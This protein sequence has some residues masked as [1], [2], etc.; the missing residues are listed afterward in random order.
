MNKHWKKWLITTIVLTTAVAP[1]AYTSAHASTGA[2]FGDLQQ[3]K[4]NKQEAIQQAAELGLIS[5]DPNGQFRP[6]D[7]VTREELAVLIS[8]ALKLQPGKDGSF[9]DVSSNLYGQT[10]IQAMQA[11][12]LMAGDEDHKFRPSDSITREELATVLVRVMDGLKIQGGTAGSVSD[13]GQ[14]SGWAQDYVDSALRLKLV[15]TDGAAFNPQGNVQR[16]DI[17][18]VLLDLFQPKQKTATINSVSGD[19]VT[20][21]GVPY[22]ATGSLKKLLSENNAAALTG[23]K[24]Q[25]D[26]MTRGINQLGE[27]SIV[28]SGD[29]D[30]PL[31]LDLGGA[32]LNG[33]LTISGDHVAITGTA[34]IS[35]LVLDGAAKSVK[36][37]ANVNKL[38]VKADHAVDLQGKGKVGELLVSNDKASLSLGKDVKIDKL[39]L[40]DNTDPSKVIS[41]YTDVV[42][43]IGK[44]NDHEP[45]KPEPKPTPA[46]TPVNHK[47]VVDQSVEPIE[48]TLG[49]DLNAIPLSQV[50]SDPDHD[51]L[52]YEVST[53]DA[54]TVGFE[55]TGVA[56]HLYPHQAG[57]ATITITAKDTSGASVQ[58]KFTVTVKNPVTPPVN[59]AP[60]IANQIANQTV[61]FGEGI[62]PI[63]L[64]TAFQDDEDDLT[65]TVDSDNL[66]VVN[67]TIDAQNN[68]I[69]NPLADGTATITIHANDGHNDPVDMTFTLTVNAATPSNVAPTVVGSLVDKTIMFG[70]TIAP[71]SVAGLFADADGDD[72][73]L[74]ADTEVAGVATLS[75]DAQTNLLSITPIAAGTTKVSVTAD[76]GHG[77]TAETKFILTIN[78]APAANHA[79]TTVGSLA[80]QT[81][82]LGDTVDAI[83]VA[84]YFQDEDQD[85]LHYQVNS[86]HPEIAT[87]TVSDSGQLSITPVGAGTATFTL[88]ASDEV[89]GNAPATLTF[90]VTVNPA[91][92]KSAF[93]SEA[94][95]GADFN[96]AFE[97]YNPTNAPISFDSI[98]LVWDGGEYT[99]GSGGGGGIPGF[100]PSSV[101]TEI[102]AGGTMVFA[103]ALGDQY[104][105]APNFILASFGFD[106]ET[107]DAF[108]VSLYIDG[109]LVD[110]ILYTPHQ[111]LKRNTSTT[112]GETTYDSS[113]WTVAGE[114]DVTDL[115]SFPTAP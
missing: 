45:P 5:G 49:D 59:N 72:L 109:V 65:L 61:T 101:P 46:P 82:T 88:T 21:D 51:K 8:R 89:N 44:V 115:G 18:D 62:A 67:P 10:Y 43:Q 90:T 2:T 3:A 104:E 35:E 113:Q 12:G 30:H 25:F 31:N 93:I 99:P 100:A 50:F 97:I 81:Y 19:L 107:L 92:T 76:D 11:A 70:D 73:T 40:P 105:N 78:E 80:D 110:T 79:P 69:L 68:L 56:L 22:L 52:T 14:V 108:P 75:I 1:N 91:V 28:Q 32:T 84:G 98:R 39:T 34:S 94:N 66:S 42:G 60:T 53:S 106:I 26:T 83:E 47:P 36:V 48:V 23:A 112:H 13:N 27:M 63:S 71:I 111:T 77:H 38:N 15:P 9:A 96:Q 95:W 7:S 102:P 74:T 33:P 85:V 86:D 54:D 20:I 6:T 103:D 64:A 87:A 58:T 41:N 55:L 29:A 17:V 57:T 16:Q 24:I 4:V 37:D 114:A